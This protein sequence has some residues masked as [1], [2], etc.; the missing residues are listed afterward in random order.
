M[1]GRLD[2]VCEYVCVVADNHHCSDRHSCK[3]GGWLSVFE[4]CITLI[5]CVITKSC[6]FHNF[7]IKSFFASQID[8]VVFDLTKLTCNGIS[9]FE[10]MAIQEIPE[11]WVWFSNYLPC[12]FAQQFENVL[13]IY[14]LWCPP[15]Q[16]SFFVYKTEIVPNQPTIIFHWILATRLM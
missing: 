1:L 15:L 6:V 11:V 7:I 5:W 14:L 8:G 9:F 16:L 4:S 3:Q 2:R 13:F 10:Y 12:K